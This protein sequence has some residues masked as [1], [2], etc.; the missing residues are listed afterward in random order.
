M[1]AR[2]WACALAL[3]ALLVAAPAQAGP[4]S[5]GAEAGLGL[6]SFFASLPYGA[7]KVLWAATGTLG[8]G[9]AWCITG[10]DSDPAKKIMDGAVRGDYIL[11]PDHLTGKDSIEFIGRS[12]ENQIAHEATQDTSQ[13][14]PGW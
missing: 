9:L 10:G 8:A 4:R 13:S 6:A 2:R 14:A 12:A 7:A 5:T 11:T 1:H 3:L